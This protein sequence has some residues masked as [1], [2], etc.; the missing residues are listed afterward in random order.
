MK[1]KY[2]FLITRPVNVII[3]SLSIF[4]GAFITGTIQP[5]LK[6]I[7][8]ML[9]GGLIAGAGNAINDYFDVA[10]DKINKPHRPIPAG[11]LTPKQV[12]LFAIILFII[13]TLL[14]IVINWKAFIIASLTS[15]SLYF[16]SYRLKRTVLWGNAVVGFISALAFVFGGIAVD[17]FTA[18]LIPALFAFLFHLG[19][20]II[21]DTEDQKG[22]LADNAQTLPIKYGTNVALGITSFVFIML[23]VITLIPYFLKIYNSL[24]LI[25]VVLGV[26][27]VLIYIIYSMWKNPGPKNLGRLSTILKIDMVIGLFSVFMGR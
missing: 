24:Y 13:G 20:E 2:F 8:A 23:I 17:R 3:A 27:S 12:Y 1:I 26:H 15:I 11:F 25:I 9:S 18:S 14:G 19:R 16:Y 10:I 6:V 22:D 4:I 21:K 5:Y 7:L